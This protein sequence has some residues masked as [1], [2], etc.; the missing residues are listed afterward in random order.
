[1]KNNYKIKEFTN[2]QLIVSEIF[3]K[4]NNEFEQIYKIY[5]IE[6]LLTQFLHLINI[7]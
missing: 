7:Y 6:I 3:S 4:N 5:L 2:Y 1:M